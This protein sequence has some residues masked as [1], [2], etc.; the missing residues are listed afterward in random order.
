[1][2][3]LKVIAFGAAAALCVLQC[4]GN[5]GKCNTNADCTGGAICD[6]V[7]HV[8]VGSGNDAGTDA[9]GGDSGSVDA[10]TDAGS[11]AGL[12][13]LSTLCTS[14]LGS[15]C[16]WLTRC[17]YVANDTTCLGLIT[18]GIDETSCLFSYKQAVKHGRATFDAS[19]ATTCFNAISTTLACNFNPLLDPSSC[20]TLTNFFLV[21]SV[22]DGDACYLSAECSAQSFC[23]ARNIATCPGVCTPRSGVG[24][25]VSYSD[26]CLSPLYDYNGHCSALVPTQAS[27]APDAGASYT[28]T[29]V[30]GDFC[31]S[32][33]AC[34]PT[35]GVGQSCA[36]DSFGCQSPL[37]CNSSMICEAPHPAGTDC[38][39]SNFCQ[40][41]LTCL[42]ALADGGGGK[43]CTARAASNPCLGDQDCPPNYWC[44]GAITGT[45]FGS[46]IAAGSAGVGCTQLD[47]CKNGLF[48]NS[49]GQCAQPVGFG[50]AC[51]GSPKSGS[52]C[53]SAEGLDCTLGD[54]G[55]TC[56]PQSGVCYDYA[57]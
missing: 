15:Y 29:C 48:C 6:P 55:Y 18:Q 51:D 14:Y 44:S 36:T 11:D 42:P 26:Q 35:F 12:V 54:A 16:A 8:C 43:T 25:A 47:N 21:G 57:P 49:T 38:S 52:S 9:G 46:C 23:T 31:D 5:Q 28:Q 17:G 37:R 39:V 24:A 45:M 4:T 22:A 30:P 40:E 32:A 41:D 56:V 20:P 27:C 34:L 19:A 10:G 7:A 2:N 3:R 1:M 50:A 53:L 13:S 33:Q